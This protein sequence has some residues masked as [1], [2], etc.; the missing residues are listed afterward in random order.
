MEDLLVIERYSLVG[1]RERNCY[2]WHIIACRGGYNFRGIGH[3]METSA[4]RIGKWEDTLLSWKQLTGEHGKGGLKTEEST[5]DHRIWG[6]RNE[7]CRGFG[8]G[9]NDSSLLCTSA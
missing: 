7:M 4:I 5:H 6:K 8:K 3:Q 2:I 1:G 9:G